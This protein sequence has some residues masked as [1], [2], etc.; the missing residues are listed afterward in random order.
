M[1]NKFLFTELIVL[2]SSCRRG[3]MLMKFTNFFSQTKI[4]FIVQMIHITDTQ[5]GTD[6]I[7]FEF[8]TF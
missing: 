2:K 6:V 8:V 1:Q 4:F 3:N 5:S 7:R